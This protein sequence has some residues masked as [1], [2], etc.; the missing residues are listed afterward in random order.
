[1]I[2]INLSDLNSGSDYKITQSGSYMLG[3]SEATISSNN[4]YINVEV[5][6][7]YIYGYNV[8]G[9]TG[10]V[11]LPEGAGTTFSLSGRNNYSGFIYVKHSDLVVNVYGIAFSSM[12]NTSIKSDCTAFL[13]GDT[14]YPIAHFYNC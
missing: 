6:N 12:T 13:N 11:G 10:N 4:F 8:T 1:M 14:G 5:S 7:V 2:T 9:Q 3:F